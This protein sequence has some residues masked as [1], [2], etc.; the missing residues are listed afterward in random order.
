MDKKRKIFLYI[1]GGIFSL[2]IVF[3]LARMIID[4]PYRNQIPPLP[5]MN[6]ISG[7]LQE[8][9]SEACKKARHNPTAN[10]LGFLG[11]VYHS[12]TFYEQAKQCY[13][14]AI[15]KNSSKWIWNYYLGYLNKEMGENAAAIE[16][17]TKVVEK[18][19]KSRLAWFYIGEGY[20]AMGSNDKAEGIFNK[21]ISQGDRNDSHGNPARFDYFPLSTY[22]R[23]Q[24]ANIY[25]NTQRTDLA[26]KTLI[27][28]IQNQKSFGQAYRLLGRVYSMKGDELLSKKYIAR[29]GDLMI[30]TPPVDAFADR[31]ALISR[32]EIYVM[33]Q[34]DDAEKGGYSSF[35]IELINNAMVNIPEDKFLIS[36]AIKLYI[37]MNL[38]K[39]ALPYF[40]RHMQLFGDDINEIKMVADMCMKKGLYSQAIKYYTRAAKLQ[41]DNIDVKLSNILCLGNAGMKKQA[42]DSINELFEKNKQNLKVQTDG[43]YVMLMLGEKE[44]AASNLADLKK[45][46]PTNP[47]VQQLS[48]ILLQQ[49]GKDQEALVMYESSFNGNPEDLSTTRYLCDLL[50]KKKMWDKVINYYSKAL[51]YHP[52]EPYLLENLGTLLIMC[53]DL[54]MRNINKGVEFAERAFINKASPTRTII[55]AGRSLAEGYSALGDKKNAVNCINIIIGLARRENAPKEFLIELERKLEEYKK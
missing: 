25:L 35:G 11:M 18:N 13:I 17:F 21:I 24:L 30:Y 28:I 34:I 16:N 42:L 3:F 31:L 10:N 41:P 33:K 48:G 2:A 32:S 20:Q 53:P 38:D 52:N 44:K 26:E 47:K 14:L 49:D 7:P 4:N 45:L 51:E 19:P 6:T 1:T 8:Q 54:N 40:D 50:M 9:I 36:K 23:F 15:K 5:E 37:L 43:V 39:Q 22:A 46:S 27:D 29:A 12:G 55:S